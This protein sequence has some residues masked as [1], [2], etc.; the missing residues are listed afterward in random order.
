M[1]LGAG[2]VHLA[3]D[4]DRADVHD[5]VAVVGQVVVGDLVAGGRGPGDLVV[6][7]DVAAAAVGHGVVR[8]RLVAAEDVDPG[9]VAAAVVDAGDEVVGH[10]VARTGQQHPVSGAVVDSAVAQGV[11]GAL[12]EDSA[13]GLTRRQHVAGVGGRDLARVDLQVH[14]VGH[15][16]G[17]D[18]VQHV[19]R[20]GGRGGHRGGP[21][22]EADDGHV[23]APGQVDGDIALLGLDGVP[24]RARTV[25][26]PH[27]EPL[28]VGVVVPLAGMAER[29]E[30]AGERVEVLLVGAEADA[31]GGQPGGGHG[32]DRG[33]GDGARLADEPVVRG[34]AGPL[35]VPDGLGQ[36]V[37][38]QR[39]VG[40]GVRGVVVG[41]RRFG[42]RVGPLGLP[43]HRAVDEELVAGQGGVQGEVG[44]VYL[45]GRGGRGEVRAAQC[46]VGGL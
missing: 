2:Q 43:Q 36:G 27:V 46:R 20:G 10:R 29:L 7:V 16:A 5:Q 11:G 45:P 3:A 39:V 33:R 26:H 19:V 28:R 22:T 15:V 42:A 30:L 35:P 23:G 21:D 32:A 40:A 34:Q 41:A 38:V 25:R 8:D 17:V 14:V 9:G 6:D 37:V 24:R 12:Q 4:V 31:G 13:G 18:A 1:D 44:P